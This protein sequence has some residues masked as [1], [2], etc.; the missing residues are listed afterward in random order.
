MIVKGELVARGQGRRILADEEAAAR[1]SY[2]KA[3]TKRT[4]TWIFQ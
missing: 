2:Q 4:C 3:H 1:T